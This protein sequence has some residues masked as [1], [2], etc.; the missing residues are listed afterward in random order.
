MKILVISLVISLVKSLLQ[1]HA[2]ISEHNCMQVYP[3]PFF[4]FSNFSKTPIIRLYL[5]ATQ[6]GVTEYQKIDF[7]KVLDTI[8]FTELK[9]IMITLFD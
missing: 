8:S 3:G 5:H 9:N 4:E 6:S 7:L 1:L 2:S